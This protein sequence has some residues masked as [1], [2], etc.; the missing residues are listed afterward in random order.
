MLL[1]EYCIQ[2]WDSRSAN[3]QKLESQILGLRFKRLILYTGYCNA[4][5]LLCYFWN[6]TYSY[7]IIPVNVTVFKK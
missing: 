1:K 2:F 5:G 3:Y 7:V 6:A 4:V